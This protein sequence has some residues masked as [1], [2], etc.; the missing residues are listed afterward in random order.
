VID[1]VR[2]GMRITKLVHGSYL[3]IKYLNHGICLRSYSTDIYRYLR[4]L[5]PC[6]IISQF[7]I[8]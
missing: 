8:M 7:I 2:G 4:C 1:E 6:H 5:S 3:S